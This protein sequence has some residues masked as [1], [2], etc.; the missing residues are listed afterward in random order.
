MPNLRSLAILSTGL[1]ICLWTYLINAALA[2]ALGGT[3]IM[4]LYPAD[5]VAQ[6]GQF[7]PLYNMFN[8]LLGLALW[9]LVVL[10]TYRAHQN[11][12]AFAL[13]GLNFHPLWAALS[14][15]VP[16]AN[17]FVPFQAMRELVNRSNGEEAHFARQTVG[18]ANSWWTCYLVGNLLVVW[19]VFSSLIGPL[20]GIHIVTPVPLLIGTIFFA[21]TLLVT[22]SWFLLRLV[23]SV[24]RAQQGFTNVS[25]TF[26]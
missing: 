11:L 21:M 2:I 7:L 12:R 17:L 6:I 23:D 5:V 22:A 14:Y 1:K 16:I 20:T 24:N 10:W 15:F 4:G 9:V 25:G 13:N 18:D 26:A 19:L 3:T 8:L